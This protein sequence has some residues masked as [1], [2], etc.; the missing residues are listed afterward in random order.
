MKKV[1]TQIEEQALHFLVAI[2]DVFRDREDR[3][4]EAYGKLEVPDD[5]TGVV[6]AMLL[7]MRL[8]VRETTGDEGS[9]LIGFTHL[10]NKLAIQQ[11]MDPKEGQK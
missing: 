6:T 3:E 4:L 9:D 2:T 11:I 5:L 7:A 8:F 1:L 10:L